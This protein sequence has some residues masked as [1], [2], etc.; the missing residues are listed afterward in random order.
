MQCCCSMKCVLQHTKSKLSQLLGNP[1]SGVRLS[2][3]FIKQHEVEPSTEHSCFLTSVFL[4]HIWRKPAWNIPLVI[5][6]H[7]IIKPYYNNMDFMNT[8]NKNSA[9]SLKYKH[10]KGLFCLSYRSNLDQAFLAQLN[11]CC[12]SLGCFLFSHEMYFGC[13]Y[14]S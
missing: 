5:W 14:P 6:L 3:S 1:T 8:S 13:L 2:K 7:R 12:S 11:H 4:P 10:S 9:A